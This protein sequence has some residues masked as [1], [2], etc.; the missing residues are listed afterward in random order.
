MDT[1]TIIQYDPNAIEAYGALR[2]GVHIA[3]YTFERACGKL[4]W[5]LESDRWRDVGNGFTN[6]NAF[7]DSIRL[8]S[9]RAVAEQ[10]KRIAGRI[11][12]LQP[13][14]SNR[15]IAKTLG[16]SHTQVGRDL[17]TNVPAADKKASKINASQTPA[18]TNVPPVIAGAA[19]AQLVQRKE[20]AEEQREEN[21]AVAK[22]AVIVP[23][24]KFGTIV[25]D[26]PWEME[27]IERDVR[28]NQVA[29]DYP[30]MSVGEIIAFRG[31]IDAVAAEDVHLFLCTTQKYLPAAFKIIEAWDFR[32]VLTMVWHKSGGF[33]PIGLPQYN[34]E[35]IIYARRGT[36]RFTDT[37]AFN[38]CFAGERREHSRKPDQF[39][40]VIRRVTAE[41]RIDMFSREAHDGFAQ[42]GNERDRFKAA[43]AE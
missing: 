19:A 12:Q 1:V 41:P 40:D 5:L 8:D 37:K 34:C 29:F 32:Y 36:P 18:G 13:K 22:T 25:I 15:Q 24:G 11:K 33:Q 2:E 6:V 10:R 35:F 42:Y 4:E 39:Y 7:L 27:K 43:A 16:S 21:A 31:M 3:G 28:P 20:R 30:T 17:G 14:V 9:F 26:P 38:C 23:A